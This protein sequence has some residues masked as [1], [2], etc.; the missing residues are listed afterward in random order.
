MRN[1]K[2]RVSEYA[3]ME[4]RAAK[5]G[6]DGVNKQNQ[7]RNKLKDNPKA[8]TRDVQKRMG[9]YKSGRVDTVIDKVKVYKNP[10]NK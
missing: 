5:V 7:R 10:G 8:I 1:I 6:Y 9:E 3:R 4:K 2:D